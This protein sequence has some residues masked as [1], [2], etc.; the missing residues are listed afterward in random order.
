MAVRVLLK[1]AKPTMRLARPILD[2]EG[3]LVAGSGTILGASVLRV[4]RKMAVQSVVVT[5]RDEL[6]AWET[7]RPLSEEVADVEHRF[8]CE[9]STAPL[10]EL[11]KALVRHLGK[12]AARL[13]GEVGE[14]SDTPAEP[15]PQRGAGTTVER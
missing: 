9:P 15:L 8:G 2:G 4:L 13:E 14:A 7:V 3:K 12:R 11:R 1:L 10:S 6:E 5:D